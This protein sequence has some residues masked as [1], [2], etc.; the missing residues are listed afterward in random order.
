[1]NKV[2]KDLGPPKLNPSKGDIAPN[3][4]QT[5]MQTQPTHARGILPRPSE[6]PP[7]RTR[8]GLADLTIRPLE[9]I[10]PPYKYRELHGDEVRLLTLQSGKPGDEIVLSISHVP[11]LRSQPHPKLSLQQIQ[12][13]LPRGWKVYEGLTGDFFYRQE[14]VNTKSATQRQHPRPGS[15][16]RLSETFGQTYY[17]AVSYEALSYTWGTEASQEAVNV[18]PEAM[19]GTVDGES[20][21]AETLSVRKNLASALRRLR[22]TDRPRTIWVDAICIDQGNTT[23]RNRQVQRATVVYEEARRV[24]VWLGPTSDDSDLAMRILGDLGKQVVVLKDGDILP[25][26]GIDEADWQ[27]ARFTLPYSPSTWAAIA[28]LLRRPWFSRVWILQ[29]VLLSAEA[30]FVCGDQEI[31]RE[32]LG[33]ALYLMK[34]K[35]EL[36]QLLS[37]GLINSVALVVMPAVISTWSIATAVRMTHEA[38]CTL[39]KDSIYGAL[40]LFPPSFRTRITV[41]YSLTTE[42]VYTNFVKSHIEHVRRL[43]MFRVCDLQHQRLPRLPS[44]V[45]DF[46]DTPTTP[47]GIGNW[48]FCSGYSA[49]EVSFHDNTL[50]AAGVC[51]ATVQSVSD[52]IPNHESDTGK[53]FADTVRALQKARDYFEH[54]NIETRVREGPEA[55]I[56]TILGGFL[57]QRL[58]DNY[59]P[60]PRE[61][62]RQ[63]I[64]QSDIFCAQHAAN[65]I[66]SKVSLVEDF[67]LRMM[68]GK[69]V[70]GTAAGHW[71]IA[72]AATQNGK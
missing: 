59:L 57:Q 3:S 24:I 35:T 15:E 8:L 7:Q 5:R 55:F 52:V 68:M 72:P 48:S 1:M 13:D 23:E 64:R 19:K 47:L 56:W 29:E 58:P 18:I 54:C 28:S 22:Y 32:T 43:E 31:S 46:F 37:R 66:E 25:A 10:M 39:D 70:V 14:G 27:S 40:G 36:G 30:Q 67:C 61:H 60:L 12:A 6:C 17:N 41:D 50:E 34:F 20:L 63:A 16:A 45:P 21:A 33:G 2:L 53:E 49:S 62:L 71:G 51:A 26:P 42:V 38:H 65:A 11:L 9:S 44:W 69:R 4:P